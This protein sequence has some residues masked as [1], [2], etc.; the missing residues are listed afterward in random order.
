ME[1][2]DFERQEMTVRRGKGQRDRRV[3]LPDALACKFP[4][5]LFEWRW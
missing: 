4:N 5:A 1:D 3:V 2:V